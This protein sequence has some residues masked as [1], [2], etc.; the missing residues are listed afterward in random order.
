MPDCAVV[1]G[2]D[3]QEQWH[4][5]V[6]P[7]VPSN[8]VELSLGQL[9]YYINP[10]DDLLLSLILMPTYLPASVLAGEFLHAAYE[11]RAV[12]PPLLAVARVAF[13]AVRKVAQVGIPPRFLLR[14]LQVCSLHVLHHVELQASAI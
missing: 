12:L 14:P 8:V 1:W 11:G 10:P 9:L 7:T 2:R 4:R 6:Y 13:F 3:S 5:T